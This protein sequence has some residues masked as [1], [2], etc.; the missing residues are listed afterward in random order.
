M[1]IFDDLVHSA[2]VPSGPYMGYKINTM[3]DINMSPE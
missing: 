1:Y 2:M 3:S